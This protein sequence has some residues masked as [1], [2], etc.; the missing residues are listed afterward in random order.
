MLEFGERERSKAG[1]KEEDF[2]VD[3]ISHGKRERD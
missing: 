1:E 3:E 2:L